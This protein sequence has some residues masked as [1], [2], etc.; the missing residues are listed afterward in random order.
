M[1]LDL[2]FGGFILF[3]LGMAVFAIAT[4]FTSKSA[5]LGFYD[6]NSRINEVSY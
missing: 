3:L 4:F 5:K 2:V 1:V 6:A